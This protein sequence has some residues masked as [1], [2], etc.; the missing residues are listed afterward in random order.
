MFDDDDDDDV[1]EVELPT[2]PEPVMILETF[3]SD[4]PEA[5]KKPIEKQ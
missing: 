5:P 3:A 2:P 1:K 4:R